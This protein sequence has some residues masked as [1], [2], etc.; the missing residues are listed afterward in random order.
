MDHNGFKKLIS[1]IIIFQATLTI[2]SDL[3]LLAPY[4][5]DVAL[6]VATH[7]LQDSA[8]QAQLQTGF[9]QHLPLIGVP[10][11]QA[12]DL[13]SFRLAN[14][15]TTCLGLIGGQQSRHETQVFLAL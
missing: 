9:V 12:V 5:I 6:L 7:A 13:H 10:G 1:K 14:T 4:P 3:Q 15:M 2:N 8:I 11:D